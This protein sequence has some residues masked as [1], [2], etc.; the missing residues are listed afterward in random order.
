MSQAEI[1]AY[2]VDQS[3]L[4]GGT[5]NSLVAPGDIRYVDLNGDNYID[6]RDQDEIG[7]GG[8]PD[9]TYG[10]NLNAS[11]KNFSL[12]M[13]LQGASGF[14]FTFGNQIRNI[15]INNVVPYKFQYD[16][17]WTPDPNDPTVNIN[18]NAQL[19]ASTAANANANNTQVSDFW[20]Q[21]GTYLRLKNLNFGYELPQQIKDF[22]GVDNFRLFVSG[23]NL[24]TWNNL[25]I[26]KGTFDSEGPTNQDGT[27]YPLIKTISYGINISL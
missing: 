9:M 27:T 20:L 11:Y 19:P 12:S 1:D 23:S 24:I 18:P 25:G 7:K 4:A 17:R 16:Y 3:L 21:D 5:G 14:N 13:L 10:I 26:Y 8:L 15:L 22:I 2:P 6:W